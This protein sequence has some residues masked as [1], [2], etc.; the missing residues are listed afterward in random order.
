MSVP[1]EGISPEDQKIIEA[2]VGDKSRNRR[3]YNEFYK[4]NKNK[5]LPSKEIDKNES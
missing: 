4:R 5:A 2:M 1:D 3:D